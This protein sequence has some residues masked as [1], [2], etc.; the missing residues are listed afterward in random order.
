MAGL[1]VISD[2]LLMQG[3]LDHFL[4]LTIDKVNFSP[5]S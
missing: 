3:S 4:L 5:E 2:G 1:G